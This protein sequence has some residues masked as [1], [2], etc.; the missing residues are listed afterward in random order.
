MYI[1]YCSTGVGPK[2]E[3]IRIGEKKMVELKQVEMI[4]NS[5]IS[6]IEQYRHRATYTTHSMS[7]SWATDPIP[8]TDL[9]ILAFVQKI[10]NKENEADLVVSNID[11]DEFGNCE[12]DQLYPVYM[13]AVKLPDD[14]YFVTIEGYNIRE[15]FDDEVEGAYTKEYILEL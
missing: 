7:R 1:V 10:A 15:W 6:L 14:R 5:I 2:N 12:G 8:C 13:N 11:W 3:K 9:E 4:Q